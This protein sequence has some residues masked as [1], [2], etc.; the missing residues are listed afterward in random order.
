MRKCCTVLL[1]LTLLAICTI[2]ATA[3][4]TYD[5]SDIM[6]CYADPDGRV[7]AVSNGG[8]TS[9]Y[10]EN[11]IEAIDA[12][13]ENGADIVL[14]NVKMTA[15][16]VLILFSD[17]TTGRML[18]GSDTDVSDLTYDEISSR[19]LLS[20]TGGYL[21]SETSYTVATLYDALT[22]TDAVLMISDF[23][24]YA[25]DI[26]EIL[27][28]ADRLDTVILLTSSASA[29]DCADWQAELG[30][31]CEI[32][33]SYIGNIIFNAIH[34]VR[35]AESNGLGGVFLGTSNP[36]GV[37]F[38]STVGSFCSSVRTMADMTQDSTR[39]S[40][41]SDTEKWWDDLIS[42]GFSMLVTD[43]ISG[44]RSYLDECDA[45]YLTLTLLLA[46]V[47]SNEELDALPEASLSDLNDALEAG[48]EL[49]SS[50]ANAKTDL[51][52]A[53]SAINEALDFLS[54]NWDEALN[55][56][57]GLT[58]TPGRIIAAVICGAGVIAGEIFVA[59]KISKKKSG[60]N[61]A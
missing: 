12:A 19:Y 16:G 23:W 34:T 27:T 9:C 18:T 55:G 59:K 30:I 53:I 47:E 5:A 10:P 24:D 50:K 1:T 6:E 36:Y 48:E 42:R 20:G 13:I 33:T 31:D 40:L 22:K 7:L 44:L 8:D 21:S 58:I 46:T 17:D 60:V 29:S 61:A 38:G 45:A 3:A 11:S 28:E 26:A 51:D 15:D 2:Y 4:T 49:I 39:S 37:V 35:C 14:V 57:T 54:E 41:R 32:M 56:T 43:N 52:D 25:D